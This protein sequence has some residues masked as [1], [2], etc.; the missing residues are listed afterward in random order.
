MKKTTAL[1]GVL[2]A[3]CLI[4]PVL[5]ILGAFCG[6]DVVVKDW[7]WYGILSTALFAGLSCWLFITKDRTAAVPGRIFAT[8]LLPAA[9]VNTLFWALFGAWLIWV[10][11]LIWVG[12]SVAV[13]LVY[14]RSWI[15]KMAVGVVASFL[16]A[17][18]LVACFVAAFPIG[19]NTV[20]QSVESPNG[21]YRAELIDSDQGALGGDTLVVVHYLK[22]E[23]D[24][25][26]F[27]FRRTPDHVYRG[28]WGRFKN[29]KIGW[30]SEQELLINGK[31][32]FVE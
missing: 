11:S 25:F 32:Y 2:L 12:F 4:Y 20:V 16:A 24:T 8:L 6:F 30:K 10:L 31:V 17:V 28:D 19:Q 3:M 29:M 5:V 21:A 23:V 27:L 15:T 14:P 18:T 13:L 26:V 22:E 7:T 1:L 9:L